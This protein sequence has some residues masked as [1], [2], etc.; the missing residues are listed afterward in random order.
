MVKNPPAM[1]EPQ[2]SSL[3]QENPLEEGMATHSNIISWRIPRINV[4]DGPQSIGLQRVRHDW[5]TKFL[6][7]IYLYFSHCSL[8]PT[9]T[10]DGCQPPGKFLLHSLKMSH[11]GLINEN[12]QVV[13][14]KDL[15]FFSSFIDTPFYQALSHTT[16]SSVQFSH[17]VV[18][19]SVIPWTATCQAFLSI[20]NS[21]SLLK[22]MSIEL[23][24]PSIHFILCCPLLLPPSVFPNIGVFYNESVFPI[25]WPKYWN[26]SYSINPSN[27]HSGFI[28][29]RMEWLDFLA[30][31]GILKSLLKNHNSKASIHQCSAFFIVQLS[32]PYM[33]TGKAIAF[34]R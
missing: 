31:Q 19:N 2:V 32:H 28:S 10:Q 7:L 5:A 15:T 8:I 12:I 4:T 27:E 29:F 20:M 25:R 34:T 21:Q 17:S 18:S 22:L 9:P 30:A 14:I 11:T 24:M 23:V 33:S 16:E 1:K 13:S 3:G 6:S 26:F